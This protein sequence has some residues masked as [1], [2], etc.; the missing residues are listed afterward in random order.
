MND[1]KLAIA[2]ASTRLSQFVE[3]KLVFAVQNL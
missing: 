3:E 1:L 2:K